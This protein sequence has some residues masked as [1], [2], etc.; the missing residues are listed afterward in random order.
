[1]GTP[2][3][4]LAS[5]ESRAAAFAIDAAVYMLVTKLLVVGGEWRT[6]PQ[7]PTV[8]WAVYAAITLLYWI[9]LD[10]WLTTP[11]KWFV[12]L[13]VV[14]HAGRPL[15]FEQWLKRSLFPGAVWVW[16]FLTLP[17]LGRIQAIRSSESDPFVAYLILSPILWFVTSRASNT[18]SGSTT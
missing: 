15:R 14:D 13:R 8:Q 6:L 2:K 3:G 12:G 5:I 16:L 9:G 18:R 1:M 17:A 4:S 11:A 7:N 10:A